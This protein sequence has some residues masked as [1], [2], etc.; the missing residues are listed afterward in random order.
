MRCIAVTLAP[1]FR[2]TEY[3]SMRS[4]AGTHS[5]QGPRWRQSMM[6]W[7]ARSFLHI[8]HMGSLG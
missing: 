3:S 2:H 1:H 5:W 4:C 8:G 6:M 7:P